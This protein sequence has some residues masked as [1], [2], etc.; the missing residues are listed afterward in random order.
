MKIYTEAEVKAQLE[1]V[2]DS[3][4]NEEVVIQTRSGETFSIV[5]KKKSPF[6]VPGITTQA[7][8]EDILLAVKTPRRGGG[9]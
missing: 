6:D 2:L 9:G 8:T 7:T 5:P 3:A 1:K 4:K